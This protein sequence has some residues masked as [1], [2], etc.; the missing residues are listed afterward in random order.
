M[1]GN[2]FMPVRV[3]DPYVEDVYGRVVIPAGVVYSNACV[4]YVPFAI[5]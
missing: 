2:T 3:F 1:K 4:L 5:Q